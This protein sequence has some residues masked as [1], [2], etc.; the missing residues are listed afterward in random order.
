MRRQ[1]AIG[2]DDGT[3]LLAD[4]DS[5][6]RHLFHIGEVSRILVLRYSPDGNSLAIGTGAG[7][8]LMATLTNDRFDPPTPPKELALDLLTNQI[9]TPQDLRNP[10]KNLQSLL[11]PPEVDQ[12]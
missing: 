7:K 11:T 8:L 3:V 5:A 12:P 1:L 9:P 2:G 10:F 4:L 6:K